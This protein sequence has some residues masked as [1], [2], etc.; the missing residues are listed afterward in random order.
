M[1]MLS[2]A[3]A[4]VSASCKQQVLSPFPD[5]VTRDAFLNTA[6]RYVVSIPPCLRTK[7]FLVSAF[8]SQKHMER[9]NTPT[10]VRICSNF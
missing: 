8:L 10:N 5:L 1:P 3:A 4:A 6:F 7:F 2:G 9:S